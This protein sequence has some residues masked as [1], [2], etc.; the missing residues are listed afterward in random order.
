M[1]IEQLRELCLSVKGA[2]ESCPFGDDTLVFKVMGKMFAF[3]G[4]ERHNGDFWLNLK[5][6]PQRSMELRERYSYIFKPYHSTDNLLWNTICVEQT[7]DTQLQEL[8]FH[9]RDEVIKKLPKKKQQEYN[10]LP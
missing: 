7:P 6:N 2:S 9:S 5:C 1:N 3:V 4:L 8:I 10:D